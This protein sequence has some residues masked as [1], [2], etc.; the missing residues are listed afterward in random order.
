MATSRFDAMANPRTSGEA[1]KREWKLES[2]RN[3]ALIYVRSLLIGTCPRGVAAATSTGQIS[4]VR[5]LRWATY[6]L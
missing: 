3:S 5:Y 4:W 1:G 6:V 2:M